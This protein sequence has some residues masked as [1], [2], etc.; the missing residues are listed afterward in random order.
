[1]SKQVQRSDSVEQ[2]LIDELVKAYQ[3]EVTSG[4]NYLAVGTSLEGL[5]GDE[6]GA[7]LIVD[8]DEEMAHAKQLAELLD[9]TFD[10]IVPTASE[11]DA[12]RQPYL[13]GLGDE[14]RSADAAIVEVIEGVIEAESEAI[15]RY[16]RIVEL[17]TEA[18]YPD[19]RDVAAGFVADERG[20]LDE[21]E[22]ALEQF[23]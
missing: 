23:S 9:V 11:V 1:M 20:H 6:I 18:G 19:V 3:D 2:K 5:F 7:D 15:E 14:H 12:S 16:T 21:M 4:L 8:F 10:V 17:A 22:S 13:D